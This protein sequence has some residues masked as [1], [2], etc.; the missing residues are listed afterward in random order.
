MSKV[1]VIGDLHCPAEHPKYLDF[2]EEL[3]YEW[4]CDEVAF[5]GDIIDWHSISYHAKDPRLPGPKDEYELTLECIDRWYDAFPEAKVCIGNHDRRI[6]RLAESAGI[7]DVM[8]K[9]YSEIWDT[10]NWDWV[11]DVVIDNVYYMHGEGRRGLNPAFNAARSRG[12]SVVM[13]HCHSVAGV[14]WF[15]GPNERFFG[16]DVG[17]GI[18]VGKLQFAYGK[19]LDNKPI[20]A[21]G[22]VIDG[23]PYSEIMPI[24][25][26]ELY[27]K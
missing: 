19:H 20:L 5:I 8:I 3:Y 24:S 13:G 10:P 11:Y 23:I 14:K 21:A 12:M 27:A 18:D 7:P 6:H 9:S 25:K 26:G 17:C 16:L 1:L 15:A 2:C 22:V 4:E